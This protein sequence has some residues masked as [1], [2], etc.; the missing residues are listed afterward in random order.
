MIAFES[1]HVFKMELRYVFIKHIVH[2]KTRKLLTIYSRYTFF[3]P[4][5]NNIILNDYFVKKS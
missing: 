4:I 2:I 5:I 3:V 1:F